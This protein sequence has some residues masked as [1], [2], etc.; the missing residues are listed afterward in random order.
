MAFTKEHTE[1]NGQLMVFVTQ[2]ALSLT[3]RSVRPMKRDIGDA[4]QAITRWRINAISDSTFLGG[5]IFFFFFFWAGYTLSAADSQISSL[6][7]VL[8]S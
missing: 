1:D 2:P 3:P 4:Y 8:W 6:T 5:P 7:S